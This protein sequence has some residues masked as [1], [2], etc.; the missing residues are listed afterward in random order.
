MAVNKGG[1]PRK[2]IT[3]AMR[4]TAR[5]QAGHGVP[6]TMIARNLGMGANQLAAYLG[7]ELAKGKAKAN[8]MIAGTLFAKA[9]G[10]DTACLIFWA[11][12][13]MGWR[14]VTRHEVTGEDGGPVQI[15]RIERVIIDG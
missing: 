5:E 10:G 11:K 6:Y 13:Q 9:M 12:T 3:D 14:E 1:R 7:D 15:S 2:I 4:E 8:A